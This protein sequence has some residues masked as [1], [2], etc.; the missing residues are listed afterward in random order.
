VFI[1]LA[2]L[3]NV[4]FHLTYAWPGHHGSVYGLLSLLGGYK[5]MTMIESSSG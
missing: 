3:F 2:Y 5:S 1:G 4:N